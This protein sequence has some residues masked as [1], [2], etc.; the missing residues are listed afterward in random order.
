MP[1]GWVVVMGMNGRSL[2]EKKR[3]QSMLE[4]AKNAQIPLLL[5]SFT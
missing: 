2:F 3:N 4:I 5:A 1:A